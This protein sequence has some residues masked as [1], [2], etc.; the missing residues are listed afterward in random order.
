LHLTQSTDFNLLIALDALLAEGSVTGAARRLSVT[1]PAM[2]RTLAR[3]RS[4]FADPILV[5]AGRGLV[6]TPQALALRERVR[7]V[8][9]EAR[10]LVAATGQQ[11]LAALVRTFTVRASDAFAGAFAAR[12]AARV[13]REAP[14][15][16][17]RFAPEGEEDV[18]P[19]RDGRVD[20]DLGVMGPLGPEVRVQT[21]FRERLVGVVRRGHPL[22]HGRVTAARLA[23]ERHVVVSRR[24]IARGP[25]DAELAR[26]GLE[27][28]VALV[29]SGFG[30]A[31]LAAAASDLVAAVPS[32]LARAAAETVAI[33]SFALPLPLPVLSVSQ[34]W[35]P[36]LEAD[37]A[38]RL[39]RTCVRELC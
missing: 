22:A 38:H 9:E 35:H 24:G 11:P 7:A 19:L 8:V 6:P 4:A 18:A 27:R 2:S 29:V 10:A 32:R 30:E 15:V 5:R 1:T 14:G 37:P 33:D 12:L 25:I 28:A 26:R 21:L 36:R 20:L 16:A 13:A 3:I 31:L 39:L 34:A 17:L 23:R